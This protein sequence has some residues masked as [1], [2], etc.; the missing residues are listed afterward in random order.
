MLGMPFPPEH[1]KLSMIGDLPDGEVFTCTLSLRPSALA[2]PDP[3]AADAL[4]DDGNA[5]GGDSL[6][7]RARDACSAFWARDVSGI[8]QRAVLRVVKLAP[9]SGANGRYTAP[10]REFGMTVPG[11]LVEGEM[12][13]HQMACKVTLETDADL[14]R[15][16]GGFYLPAPGQYGWDA[17]TNL[18]SAG[19]AAQV[20]DSV[21]TLIDDLN[22]TDPIPG[23]LRWTVVV[24]SAGRHNLDGSVRLAPALHEVKRVNV[25]RRLD[26]QRRR[27]NRLSE[28]RIS[29]ADV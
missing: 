18:R 20:R 21:A 28:A 22:S 14:G 10:P 8:H 11:G 7:E 2:G 24:A 23:D 15:V 9:I 17:T 3:S 12:Q 16:K 6:A 4:Q 19:V 5:I 13:P 27:A 1:V 25:G 26:V 29:D